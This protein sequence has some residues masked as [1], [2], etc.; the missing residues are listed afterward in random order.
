MDASLLTL[1]VLR[2]PGTVLLDTGRPDAENQTT[3][4]FTAPERTLEAF[5]PSDVA[6]LLAALE[7]AGREG[8]YAAGFLAYEAGLAFHPVA[9]PPAGRLAWFGLYAHPHVLPRADVD[10]L[11]A[12]APEG[13]VEATQ[14]GQDAE[15]YAACV[16]AVR[17]L[18][19]EGDV[20][21]VNYTLPLRFTLRGDALGLYARLRQRQPVPY[22]AWIA[23]AERCVLS[24]S[25]E[26]FFR[27][28]GGR[29]TARPMK[30][31]AARG[32]T[33]AEDAA[34]AAALAADPKNRAENLMIVDLLRNDLSVV[35][36][37]GTVAVPRRFEVEPYATL[38]QMTSTVEG[39]LLPSASLADIVGALFPCGSVTGAPKRRAM[40][41]IAEL[42]EAPRG[43]YCGSIGFV[44]PGGDAVF[45]VAIRT[46]E[47]ETAEAEGPAGRLGVGSGIVW[48][49]DAAAEYAECRL[50]ARFLL[51]PPPPGYA[52]LETMRWEDGIALWKLHQARLARSAAALG[53]RYDAPAVEAALEDATAALLPGTPHRVRLRLEAGGRVAVEAAPFEGVPEPLRVTFA[54]EPLRTDAPLRR[55]KTTQRAAYEAAYA[56]ARAAGFDEVLFVNERGEVAEGSR[57]NVFARLSGRLVTPP[58]D[59]GALPGVYRRHLLDTWPDAAEGT[60]RPADLLAAE[61]VFVC[62]AVWGLCAA[63]LTLPGTPASAAPEVAA[64]EAAA[65]EAAGGV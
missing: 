14:L 12:T 58:L 28:A 15:T 51:D 3:L 1:D 35:C 30:G 33:P 65:G 18:I 52:L 32:A 6:P 36:R 63:T 11:L 29:L 60:L 46:I 39:Q 21:Q 61:A 53:F 62:N 19:R 47:I 42:E 9:A 26:L 55:H 64:G 43:V 20:Y 2:R 59:A 4:L 31:T 13:G 37:P 45:N 23:L 5:A 49:S 57:T 41:R 22:A 50:K 48:D 24:L 17:A 54:A 34:R 16:E 44:A 40:Q 7:A 56:Q 25:P 8:L 38:F 27:R 10:A